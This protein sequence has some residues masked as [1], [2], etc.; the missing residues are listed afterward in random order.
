MDNYIREEISKWREKEN[1]RMR[2][3]REK[4]RNNW[5]SIS[6]RIRG[7]KKV[8]EVLNKIN[9]LQVGIFLKLKVVVFLKKN[10]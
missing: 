9:K 4:K 7:M 2:K 5:C 1:E 8:V 10:Y 6:S 3:I